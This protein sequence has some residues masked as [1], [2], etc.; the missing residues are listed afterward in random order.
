MGQFGAKLGW[1]TSR[2]LSA[3]Y[4]ESYAGNAGE[5]RDHVDVV[6]SERRPPGLVDEL[7]GPQDDVVSQ[8]RHAQH[9]GRAAS[10]VSAEATRQ[11]GVA[12]SRRQGERLAGT[13]YVTRRARPGR[14]LGP[15]ELPGAL[16][17]SA[18]S[19]QG[20]AFQCQYP[21]G[22]CA[23]GVERRAGYRLEDRVHWL[24]WPRQWPAWP[25][26]GA[27]VAVDHP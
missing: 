8:A 7:K 20:T 12:S 25:H 24:T 17:G 15:Y 6:E 10:Q 22:R 13:D 18:H 5:Q 23:S 11:A 14:H 16:A 9:A 4:V 26:A 3:G 1:R 19:A 27:G 21:T 2:H